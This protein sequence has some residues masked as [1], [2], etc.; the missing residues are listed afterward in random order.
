MRGT[1]LSLK[2]DDSSLTLG[3]QPT[4]FSSLNSGFVRSRSSRTCRV[5]CEH[6]YVV[7]GGRRGDRYRVRAG[8]RDRVWSAGQPSD[9][10]WG[11]KVVAVVTERRR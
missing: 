2:V 9:R 4:F 10:A 7:S 5:V 11:N 1:L 3:R 6:R 8:C